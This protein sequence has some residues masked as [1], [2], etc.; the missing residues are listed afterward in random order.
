MIDVQEQVSSSARP[1]HT[2]R[3]QAIA[4]ARP[5]EIT[6]RPTKKFLPIAR[7]FSDAKKDPFVQLEWERRNAEITDD[8]GKV[9]FK[10]ENV[11]VPDRK[12]VV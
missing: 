6:N 12:S 4:H 10:Q 2:R 1:Q 3:R 8:A 7:V 9:I 5:P 11:E